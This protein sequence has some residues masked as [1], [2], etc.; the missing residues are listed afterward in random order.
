MRSFNRG[1]SVFG[2][3]SCPPTTLKVAPM[4]MPGLIFYV[5][6]TRSSKREPFPGVHSLLRTQSKKDFQHTEQGKT[7]PHQ[8]SQR[9]RC[10]PLPPNYK[11]HRLKHERLRISAHCTHWNLKLRHNQTG[12]PR[13]MP[14]I[15]KAADTHL[16]LGFSLALCLPGF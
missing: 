15:E 8:F 1:P 3:G 14:R 7:R 5:V 9:K 4:P 13:N 16:W 6:A 10:S 11:A 12:L 2:G